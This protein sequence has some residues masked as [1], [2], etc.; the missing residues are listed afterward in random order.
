MNPDI[1][2]VRHVVPFTVTIPT[3]A[4]RRQQGVLGP[5]SV[6][7]A[8]LGASGRLVAPPEQEVA[9]SSRAGPIA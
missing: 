6:K 5:K 2:G 9:R 8:L 1:S 7:S 3:S 4:S